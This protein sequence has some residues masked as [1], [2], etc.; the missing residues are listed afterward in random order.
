MKLK[1]QQ[2]VEEVPG[3]ESL[4]FAPQEPLQWKAGQFFHWVLHHRPTDDR[5]SE[6][7]FTCSAAPSEGFAKITTRITNEKGSSFKTALQN[8]KIGDEIEISDVDGDFVVEDVS[9]EYVFIA[10]GIGIT[11]FRSI[12][13][14]LDMTGQQINATLLYSNRDA[15]IPLKA[16]LDAFAVKNPN[17]KIHYIINPERI[18]ESKI[19]QLVP[20]LSKPMFYVSGPEPMVESF[21]TVLKSMGV[22]DTHIKQD[23]FPG[24]TAE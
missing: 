8:L 22:P 2:R 4:I 12:L 7:W 17:L 10:G 21:G 3:V 9:L 1:L 14:E 11:P 24:Y 5:G 13:K 16:E 15:N 18:D 6:R 20:D 23:W 19:R